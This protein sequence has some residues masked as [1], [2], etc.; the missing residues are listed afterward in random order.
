MLPI[1]PRLQKFVDKAL[2]QYLSSDCTP[3]KPD[4]LDVPY[5]LYSATDGGMSTRALDAELN[6]GLERGI[7]EI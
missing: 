2:E 6:V 1:S 7:E 4:P 5:S 3:Q